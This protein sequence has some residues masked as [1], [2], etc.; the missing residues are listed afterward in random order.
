MN[1]FASLSCVVV[2]SA[3]C[4]TLPQVTL[5][6]HPATWSSSAAITQTV[7]CN[8]DKTWLFAQ[9]TPSLTTTYSSDLG[10]TKSI[11]L[12]DLRGPFADADFKIGYTEDG[13]I[14]SVNVESTGQGEAIVK[15]AIS[16]ASAL[17]AFAVA[18]D[19]PTQTIAACNVIEK[20]GDKKTLTLSYKATVVRHKLATSIA[21]DPAPESEGLYN[22]M[23]SDL[24]KL[25]VRVGGSTPINSGPVYPDSNPD[26][27]NVVTIEVQKMGLV[28]MEFLAQG[29]PIGTSRVV[30]PLEEYSKVPIPKAPVFGKQTFVLGLYDSGAVSNLGY[31]QTTGIAAVLNAA[32]ALAAQDTS[33]A[34]AA[35]LKAQADVIAQQ[36]RLVL[37]TTKPAECK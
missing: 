22:L 37:C 24:P 12:K 13:R 33:S 16:L 15:S 28:T 10:V 36:Q 27:S 21:L 30:V 7:G 32:G 20:F 5:Q 18:L 8:A 17:G 4:A 29:K 3:G 26:R 2:I 6:Y 25:E 35:D 11:S 1:R 31:A 9:H 23:R 14:K 34:K 19:V